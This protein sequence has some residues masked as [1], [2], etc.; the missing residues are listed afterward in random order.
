MM[1]M[2]KTENMKREQVFLW[3]GYMHFSVSPYC[4]RAFLW[5]CV[6][7]FFL[8]ELYGGAE[9]PKRFQ[10]V[11]S[12]FLLGTAP[13]HSCILQW[14]EMM[15]VAIQHTHTLFNHFQHFGIVYSVFGA[16][17][18]SKWRFFAVVLVK[19]TFYVM[20]GNDFR[21]PSFSFQHII[22]AGPMLWG[23]A[24]QCDAHTQ[25]FSLV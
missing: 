21:L 20:N 19:R 10:N 1:K 8:S 9:W 6:C 15:A 7:L 2:N 22:V 3:L 13:I 18:Y 11:I 5:H 23:D 25:H 12:L 24:I 14:N 17:F 16:H 4:R